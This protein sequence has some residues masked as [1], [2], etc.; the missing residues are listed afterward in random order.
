MSIAADIFTRF[1][2]EAPHELKDSDV[3][4]RV[5]DFDAGRQGPTYQYG[6][7]LAQHEEPE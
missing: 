6:Q 7:L 2:M 3:V 4:V 1:V 5:Y